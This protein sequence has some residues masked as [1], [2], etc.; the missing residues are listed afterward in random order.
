[1]AKIVALSG[2][3]E[4]MLGK[5]GFVTLPSATSMRFYTMNMRT[6]S[7]AFGGDLDRGI[8]DGVTCDQEAGPFMKVPNMRI[9]PATGLNIKPPAN[10]S[11]WHVIKLPRRV[12]VDNRNLQIQIDPAYPGGADLKTI[13]ALLEPALRA[14]SET[15]IIWAACRAINLSSA[16]GRALGVNTLQR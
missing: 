5:E 6:L 2:H 12:P 4:W 7:D 1:M 15:M 11:N 10:P 16:G 9:F 3:G 14:S 13:L 8:I